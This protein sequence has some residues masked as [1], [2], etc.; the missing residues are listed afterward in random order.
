MVSEWKGYF[1]FLVLQLFIP[2]P[3]HRWRTTNDSIAALKDLYYICS[4][5]V[6]CQVIYNA[7]ELC[8]PRVKKQC[9]KSGFTA[10]FS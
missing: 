3:L 10:L 1:V 8:L 6:V 5:S 9:C 2:V 7:D 4:G